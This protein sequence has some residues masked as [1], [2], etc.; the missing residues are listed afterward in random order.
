MLKEELLKEKEQVKKEIEKGNAKES[1]LK[2]YSKK[3]IPIK[4]YDE[5]IHPFWGVFT[6]EEAQ[7]AIRNLNKC[8]D[9]D[10]E[11]WWI[12]FSSDEFE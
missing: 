4:I 11:K 9:T 5:L 6:K 1:E 12:D 7:Y 3:N 8:Q 10:N 2:K